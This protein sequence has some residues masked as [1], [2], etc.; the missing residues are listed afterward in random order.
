VLTRDCRDTELSLPFGGST[1]PNE[2]DSRVFHLDHCARTPFFLVRT[3]KQGVRQG[4]I[5]PF[6]GRQGLVHWAEKLG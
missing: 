4:Q 1:D 5:S 3:R 6:K 2:A